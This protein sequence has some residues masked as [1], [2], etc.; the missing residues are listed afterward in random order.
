[1]QTLWK[2]GAKTACTSYFHHFPKH[3]V[4]ESLVEGNTMERNDKKM[5][6][7]FEAFSTAE[8][9]IH[10]EENW[11]V[12]SLPVIW[13]PCSTTGVS[14]HLEQTKQPLETATAITL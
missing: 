6:S 5:G 9:K 2:T 12:N 11:G 8:E 4:S 3:L 7:L 13:P 10:E 14:E 1:M